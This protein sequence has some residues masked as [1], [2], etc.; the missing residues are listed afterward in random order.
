MY[1]KGERAA[2]AL[3]RFGRHMAGEAGDRVVRLAA[4]AIRSIALGVVLT[5]IVQAALS[6]IG[7]AI[8][9]VP[10]AALLAAVIFVLCIAQLGPV[11]VLA[12]GVAWLYWQGSAGAATALLVWTVVVATLDNVLR[13]MLMTKGG[14]LPMLLMFAGVMGGLL[15][16]GLI[17]IFVG[18]VVL[19]VSYTLLVAWIGDQPDAST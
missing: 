11:L 12:A 5:A 19:A 17:G 10:F 7:L 1:A 3:L 18:P 13:P 6:G 9:G 14:D 8:A 4:Q 16:S 15:A 2:G